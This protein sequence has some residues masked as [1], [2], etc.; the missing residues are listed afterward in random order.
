MRTVRARETACL[1]TAHPMTAGPMDHSRSWN[2]RIKARLLTGVAAAAMVSLLILGSLTWR[3]DAWIYDHL[4]RSFSP[5]VDDRIVV[6]AIDAKSLAELGR[7]PWSR[8]IHADLVNRLTASGVKGVALNILLSE[9]ALFDPEG[10]ALLA[11][12]LNRNGKVV[13]PVYAAPEHADG[14]AVEFLPIPEFAGSAVSLGHVDMPVDADGVARNAFL[15]AGLGSAHWPSLA[16]A[17]SQVGTEADSDLP[18]PGV[19]DWQSGEPSPKR[20]VRDYRVL[21][22]Y[23]D[24]ADAFR[25]VSYAD[26]LSGRVPDPVLRGHWV[27]VGVTAAGMGDGPATFGA[28]NPAQRSGVDYQANVLN[29]LLQENAKVPL[30]LTAQI[31]LSI[32]LV[33]LPLLLL[34]LRGLQDLWRPLAIAMLL[35]AVIAFLLLR[36]ANL[37]FPPVPALSVLGL[38]ALLLLLRLLRRARQQAT[39]DPLTRLPNRSKFDQGL[40]Q[41]LRSA[42]RSDQPL[43]LLMLDVDHFKRL[44]D[45]LGQPAGDEILRTFSQI[46]CGRA[47][48]PRDLVARLGGDQFAILLPETTPQSAAAIATTIHVDLANLS[49]CTS[50][51]AAVAPFTA[52]IGIHTVPAG[53]DPTAAEVVERADA[54]LYQAKQAGRNRSFSH[55]D[56]S[57][58]ASR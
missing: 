18:L 7:W 29:M 24:A 12:A 8:R 51:S 1:M 58:P 14:N 43:S 54:A 17:L 13:L 42:L 32:A 16:L 19:R 45:S 53:S 44:N 46:L 25:T 22:P 41:E 30:G 26:V 35:V 55:A 33:A 40:E 57:V 48:R 34:G 52:S 5:P 56:E 36:L 47:R 37:W 9:P 31:L 28:N 11:Q 21:V 38:A 6:V 10:D 50:A 20:W 2:T 23:T 49:T 3:A 27:L 4:A 15:R 39:S